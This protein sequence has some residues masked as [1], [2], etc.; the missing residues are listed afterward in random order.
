MLEISSKSGFYTLKSMIILKNLLIAELLYTKIES[1]QCA[2]HSEG[3]VYLMN[4][5]TQT[6]NY[7]IFIGI[8]FSVHL[9]QNLI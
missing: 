2:E 3:I 9:P 4:L 6:E 8:S 1:F 7:F 5:V